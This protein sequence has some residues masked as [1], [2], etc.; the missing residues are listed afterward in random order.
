MTF[1][2]EA[3][4]L[5]EFA[6]LFSLSSDELAARRAVRVVADSC[7][8]FP[9]RVSLQDAEIGETLVLFNYSHLDVQSPYAAAHAIFVRELA[10]QAQPKPGEVPEVLSSRLLSVRAFDVRG[11]MVD[12]DVIDGG[13]L[14][15]RLEQ[16][17]TDQGVAFID[18]HNAKPGCFAARSVRV[19]AD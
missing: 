15:S 1:Q 16:M 9:C 12:A 17:F 13:D 5:A 3:L 4:D 8:G 18:I 14:E 19:P 6:H 2:I 11:F 7:P 10:R